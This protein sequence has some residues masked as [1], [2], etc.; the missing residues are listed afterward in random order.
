MQVLKCHV[1]RPH[2]PIIAYNMYSFY[3]KN[4]YQFNQMSDMHNSHVALSL[5]C[6][7]SGNRLSVFLLHEMSG[8]KAPLNYNGLLYLFREFIYI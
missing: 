3:F 4:A 7:V 8:E 5:Y 2:R 1:K 6:R